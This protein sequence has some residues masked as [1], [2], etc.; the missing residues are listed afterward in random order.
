M[1]ENN[2]YYIAYGSNLNVRQM[3]ARCPD[4]VPYGIAD[5]VDWRLLFRGSK[6]GAYLT[7]ER[8]PGSHVPVAVWRVSE[9]DELCLDRYEGYPAFYYKADLEL[10]VESLRTGKI[11]KT[12]AFIYIMHEDRPLGVP[13]RH[14][15]STCAEG[16][17]NFGFDINI[18]ADAYE[19]SME[20]ENEGT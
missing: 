15:V 1:S 10:P 11:R 18:L 7:V 5:L 3:R 9:R 12:R 8:A 2:K 4:A 17:R 19:R 16:Y 14:Y 13:S 6:T 20:A